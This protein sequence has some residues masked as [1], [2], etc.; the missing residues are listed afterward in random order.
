MPLMDNRLVLCYNGLI[1]K[2]RK[3]ADY[4]DTFSQNS[5]DIYQKTELPP[6]INETHFLTRALILD[7]EDETPLDKERKD[8]IHSDLLRSFKSET[9]P[10]DFIFA[11]AVNASGLSD[12]IEDSKGNCIFIEKESEKGNLE[13]RYAR[14]SLI[15]LVGYELKEL[16]VDRSRQ[17]QHE[18]IGILAKAITNSLLRHGSFNPEIPVWQ[19]ETYVRRVIPIGAIPDIFQVKH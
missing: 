13:I 12:R 4:E 11:L 10:F 19:L 14:L 16:V 18:N 9:V 17:L 6:F 8:T 3:M 2:F 15:V 7:G 1:L 5:R